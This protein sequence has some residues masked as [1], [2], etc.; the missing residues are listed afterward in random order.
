MFGLYFQGHGLPLRALFGVGKMRDYV[1]ENNLAFLA[2]WFGGRRDQREW[3][4]CSPGRRWSRCLY[5]QFPP[6]PELSLLL[7]WPL[8]PL[9]PL[10]KNCRGFNQDGGIEGHG[11]HLFPQIHKKYI[12]MW[13]SYHR[14]T[15]EHYWMENLRYLEVQGRS[16]CNWVG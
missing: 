5:S 15:I 16:P 3:D 11:A 7:V 8:L 9:S 10:G 12:Y 13:N 1:V 4:Q 2:K 6:F 14:I